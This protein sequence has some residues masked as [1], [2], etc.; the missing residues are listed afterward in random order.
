[1]F[2][3]GFQWI[4]AKIIP[5]LQNVPRAIAHYPTRNQFW[6]MWCRYVYTASIVSKVS[7]IVVHAKNIGEESLTKCNFAHACKIANCP[8]VICSTFGDTSYEVYWLLW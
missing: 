3:I 6:A 8:D 7:H 1:M 5:K 2:F 4:W